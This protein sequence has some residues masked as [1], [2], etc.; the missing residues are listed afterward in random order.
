MEIGGRDFN[1]LATDGDVMLGGKDWDQRL[2]DYVAEEF[3]RKFG[4][5][6]REEPNVAR[7]L[8]ARM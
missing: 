3:I 7:P 5:D 8:V 4:V 2:V 1:A 6:P